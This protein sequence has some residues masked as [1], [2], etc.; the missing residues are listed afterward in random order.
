[1]ISKDFIKSSVIYTLAGALPMASALILLPFYIHHLSTELYGALN[2][3]LA[4]SLLVQIF[5]TFSFDT[6]LYIHF[7]EFK[8]D[9][10]KLSV[11]VS[12]AFIFMAIAGIGIGLVFTI[13][14]D[15]MF[16]IALPKLNISFFP[17]GLASVG[18][19]A[20]QALLKVHSS[21]LQS[22]ERPGTFF[23]SNVLSFT[24]IASFTII[25]LELYP[26]SLMGPVVG[27]LL[28]AFIA[29]IWVLARIFR[30]F[31]FKY[32]F[33]WLR[34]SFGFNTYTFIYQILQWIINYFDRIVMLLVLSLGDVGVY[35]FAT[36]C[37]IVL[38]LLMNGLHNS[39]YPK[40]VSAVME[41][42]E[43][44][45]TPLINRYYHGLTAIVMLAA[46]MGVLLL[47]WA[48]ETFVHKQS[49]QATIPYLPFL[50]T[51]YFF[52]TMRLYFTVPYGI[53]KYTKPL[54]VVYVIVAAMKI[55][56]MILLM[57]SFGV[58]GVI[59][60]AL[61]SAAFEIV[62]LR[63]SIKS[64]FQFRFNFFKIVGA[65]LILFIMI[66]LLEPMMGK[67]YPYT[68]HFVYLVSCVALLWW[69]YR[70]EIQLLNPLQSR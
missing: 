55:V 56:L 41:S 34:S 42:P 59:I 57:P 61:T 35:V 11:F 5:V 18:A 23:W 14:G 26:N 21:L 13:L 66:V 16:K 43:K 51:I 63:N 62:L 65:P 53:L 60:A 3:Y 10:K 49:Y 31:G 6:S 50:A 70:N 69:A 17:Y 7:H 19:G 24:M 33:T 58:F 45:S 48:I 28:A 1:L 29:G 30:E 22:R 40:V 37:L 36:Q 46:C 25:G 20:F 15:L 9:F 44:R 52:R 27:R 2:I 39:F 8:N 32:D 4:F 38:E 12:S 64:M 68:I 67:S 54:P 47:P